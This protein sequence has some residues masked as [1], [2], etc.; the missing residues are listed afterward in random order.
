MVRS[1]CYGLT[2]LVLTHRLKLM[3]R[4]HRETKRSYKMFKKR[5]DPSNKNKREAGR[6]ESVG[7]LSVAAAIAV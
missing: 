2:V 1:F 3:G 7:L 6:P 5:D 4:T